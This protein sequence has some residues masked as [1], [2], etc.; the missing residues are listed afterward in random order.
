MV[1]TMILDNIQRA[2][3]TFQLMAPRNKMYSPTIM[4]VQPRARCV[5][6]DLLLPVD[7]KPK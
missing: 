2:F 7:L 1:L 3:S 6:L 5:D 4:P